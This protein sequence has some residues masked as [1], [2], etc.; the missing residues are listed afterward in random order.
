MQSYIL[1][2]F[3]DNFDSS[4]FSAKVTFIYAHSTTPWIA[5]GKQN[6]GGSKF[7]IGEQL[8]ESTFWA[9]RPVDCCVKWE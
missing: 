7:K 9:G 2:D 6:L 1:A 3:K 5:Y 8:K 4:V